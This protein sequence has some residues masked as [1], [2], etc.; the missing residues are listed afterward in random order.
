MP[1]KEEKM[2]KQEKQTAAVSEAFTLE[3]LPG[4]GPK[5]AQ[6]LR[7]AGYE[8]LMAI[9]A[10][11]S[12]ELAGV[13]EIGESTAEKIIAAARDKLDMGFKTADEVLARRQQIGKITTGSKTLDAL[14]GGGVETQAITEMHGAFGSSKSQ[15]AF[16]LAVNVQ[17]P[18][19]QGGLNGRCLFIDT[20]ATFRPERIMAMAEAMGVDPKKALKN[21]FVARAYNSDHQVVLVDKAKDIIKEKNIRIIIIDS[22]MSH[23]RSDYSGRGELAPRQQKINRHMH[24]LQRVSEV[25]NLVVYVTNQVM[26]RPDMLFGD[27]T[28]AIG[29][30]IVGHACVVGDTLVQMSDGTIKKI[31]DAQPEE[32]LS[33]NFKNMKTEPCRSDAKFVNR[34]INEIYEIDAGSTIKASGLHR[35]FTVKDLS[36]Q[37]IKAQDMKK[38]DFVLMANNVDVKGSAQQLPEIEHDIMVTISPGGAE[39]VKSALNRY[40]ITRKEICTKLRIAPRQLRRF[41]NQKYATNTEN[42]TRLAGIFESDEIMDYI[43]PYTSNKHRHLTI[44]ETLTP[45]LAQ[46]YG[47]FLGDGNLEKSSVRFKDQRQDVLEH[48]SYLA[49]YIFGTESSIKPVKGKNCST[50]SINSVVIKR[51][52][53]KLKENYM[54]MISKSPK[55]HIAAFI[56]GFADAEGYVSKTRPMI[57]ISQK[58]VQILKYI[59]LLLLRF[60]INADI[61]KAKRCSVLLIDGRE[62]IKFNKEIGLTAEDKRTHLERWAEH[63]ENTYTREIIY[64]DRKAVWNLLKRYDFM[65]SKFMRYRPVEYKF[66][67]K[68][69]LSRVL[70]A[71]K[72]TKLIE[73]DAEKARLLHSLVNGDVILVKIKKITKKEN[74][75]PLYDLSVPKHENYI[76]NGFVVHNSTYR[77]YVRKSKGNLRIAKLIDSPNLPEGEAVF[78]VTEEGIRDK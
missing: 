47:Y 33:I 68:K 74:A 66:I 10:A 24:E 73:E 43:E 57:T 20:E 39:Y 44:P 49:D 65:P 30:H 59:R 12:G 35:F 3:D 11:S 53:S 38:G 18:K 61:R 50:L 64:V 67:H 41:L 17:L 31:K 77:L 16:Q 71:L 52:F 29:G 25:N 4:I 46:I 37:E 9:A 13:C 7:E 76:A 62:V 34:E 23:F 54:E 48:Y 26:A 19:E 51:L 78:C 6:K 21:I 56:H 55:Q 36:L 63:C 8:D 72:N 15:L 69:E 40:N 42:I 75:E 32:F 70:E 14:L 22:L 27:P 2:T 1:E 45:E 5:G 60:G 58:D 28:T